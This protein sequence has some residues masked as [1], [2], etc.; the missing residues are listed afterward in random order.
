MH[1]QDEPYQTGYTSALRIVLHCS[2][3]ADEIHPKNIL[4]VKPNLLHCIVQLNKI[5]SK[6]TLSND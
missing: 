2:I 5:S 3:L 4:I 1:K 6:L